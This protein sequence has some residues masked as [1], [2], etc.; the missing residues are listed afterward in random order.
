MEATV[1]R[2]NVRDRLLDTATRL[3]YENGY[4]ASGINEIIDAADVAKASFYH[5][6]KTKEELLITCLQRRHDQMMADLR[7]Y[8]ALGGT[9]AQRIRRVFFWLAEACQCS[10]A[11]YGCAFL[12]MTGEFRQAGSKVREV[13]KWHKN[14]FREMLRELVEAHY[15][16]QAKPM[17][18]IENAAAELY[19]LS[20][21][22][23]AAAPVQCCT[24]P[25]ET[26]RKIAEERFGLL[27]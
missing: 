22:A 23:L 11:S 16:G 27:T 21:G 1:E 2:A 6:F 15:L 13:V 14:S 4:R 7:K 8:I 25:I 17:E 12:N 3:F 24:W 9:P 18:F 5:H 19:L 20:E 10:G 26:A